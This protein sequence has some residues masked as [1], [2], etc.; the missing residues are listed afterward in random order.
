VKAFNAEGIPGGSIY[1]EQYLD[2]L[3][4]EAINSRGYQR[5]FSAQRLKAY[6]DSLHELKGNREVCA[7]TVAF[8]QNLLLAERS[9]LDHIVAAIHKIKANSAALAKA[10]S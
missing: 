9:Q 7:T 10:L 4:E 5:L 1:H 3:I 2:G 6:R 8:T